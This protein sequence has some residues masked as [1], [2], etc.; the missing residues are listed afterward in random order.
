MQIWVVFP[1][2]PHKLARRERF[3]ET[4]DAEDDVLVRAV[5]RDVKP[6]ATSIEL[7]RRARV[8]NVEIDARG[9]QTRLKM[10]WAKVEVATSRACR[11]RAIAVDEDKKDDVGV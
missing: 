2:I 5:S 4:D 1:N 6:D 8:D 7:E 3:S 10:E 11:E 9:E